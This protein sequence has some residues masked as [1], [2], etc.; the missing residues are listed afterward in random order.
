MYKLC[1]V[2]NA[3]LKMHV[4]VSL[5]LLYLFVLAMNSS[6][7]CWLQLIW[8]ARM[9]GVEGKVLYENEEVVSYL[10]LSHVAAQVLD[11]F[12][13]MLY[14]GT[15]YFAQPNAL[16]VRRRRTRLTHLVLMFSVSYLK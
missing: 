10:P 8:T 4:K 16:R 2:K 3:L 15:V 1:I 12:I 7:I 5:A 14:A 13:P 11:I 6:F 9:A